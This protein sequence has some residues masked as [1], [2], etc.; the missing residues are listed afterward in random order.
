MNESQLQGQI[1]AAQAYEALHVPALFEQW[2]G[3]VLDAVQIE[4]GERVLDVAC[5]TGVLAR[6]AAARVGAPGCVVGIDPDPGMLTVAERLAPRV[7]WRRGTAESLPYAEQSFDVVVSQFGLMFF[8]DRQKALQEMLRV[9]VPGGRLALAV[10]D[11]LDNSAAYP[12]EVALLER[13]AGPRAAD[14]LRAPFVLGNQKELTNLVDS[15]G[16]ASARITTRIGRA[17]FPSIRSMVEADLRGWLPVMGVVLEETLIES[18]LTEAENV[19]DC[20]VTT[21]GAVE[22][23]SP[24][25]IIA[26]SRPPDMPPATAD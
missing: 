8:A 20:Y 14:A 26:A 25:H 4:P 11:S 1:A 21:E 10:W 7:Q 2:A 12:E 6:E 5:G 19:L 18:I 16:F 9:L 3:R 17:R 24:A 13:M 22:F 23:D 15:A